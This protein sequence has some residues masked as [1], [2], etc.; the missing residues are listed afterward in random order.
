[1]SFSFTGVALLRSY[2]AQSTDSNCISVLKATLTFRN[3][4]HYI[5]N[6]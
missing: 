6:N 4:A 2:T 3:K 1:M 5:F